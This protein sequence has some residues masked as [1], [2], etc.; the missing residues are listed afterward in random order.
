MATLAIVGAGFCGTM[1]ATHVLRAQRSG[2][3]RVVLVERAGRE[4]G[5]V[6][7]G[8]ASTSHT[9]NVPVGRMSAFED[10]PDDY[11]RH[12]R[13]R[14]PAL[15]G[16]AF[17]PRRL[18]G[19]YLLRT[20]GEAAR[21]SECELHRVAGEA[22]DAREHEDGVRL[23]LLD[24][25]IVD[26]DQAVLAV[27]NYPPSDPPAVAE[28]L[29]T[30]LRYAR[31]PWTPDALERARDEPVLLLG[32]GLT[33]CDIVLALRD[34]DQRAPIVAIS[35][36]GLLPQAHRLSTKPPP[37][38]EP[39][40]DLEDWPATVLGLLR[41]LRREVHAAAERGVD[42]REVVTSIR[43]Q[44][45]DIWQRLDAEERRR[46]LRHARPYWETHRHR[47]SPETAFA[48]E[49]MRESGAVELLPARVA[50]VVETPTGVTVTYVPRDGAAPRELVVGKVINCTGPDTDLARV[51]DPLIRALREHGTIRPDP[52][53]LGLD[54]DEDGRLIGAAGT[55]SG[56]L[57]L[58]GPL[59]KG[60]LW[61][62]TAVPEL[63][64]EA[65]RVAER[66]CAEVQVSD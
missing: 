65:K 19:E 61:E 58:V 39:P 32:S 48:V 25:R 35:R 40:G 18:Y 38:L 44:T 50:R 24:G 12:V 64:V 45:P 14:D 26:A 28:R 59:R 2:I 9:L 46:F 33:M 5:G 55:P 53:G 56:R 57:T 11:L 63:R 60:R 3:R 34:D 37:H 43:Q 52:L 47:S 41:G 15:T 21:S 51:R 42:W 36:R 17:V 27:G 22:V 7:Y 4:I 10:D 6:A 31:D 16:G 62:H 13:N 49:S 54:T 23:T 20:L 66:L 1:V 29:A 30:S 8:T